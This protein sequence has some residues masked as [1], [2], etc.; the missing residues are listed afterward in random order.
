MRGY[1]SWA[2]LARVL[3][4]ERA[5][6][7]REVS[8]QL[9]PD[10]AD[11][12]GSLRW[13]L[14]SLRRAVDCQ[15]AFTG[16]PIRLGLPAD[17]VTDV[18]LLQSGSLALETGEEFLE[19]IE[20][21][22]G[23]E[24]ATWLLV[25][26]QRIGGLIDAQLRERAL[27]AMWGGDLDIAVQLAERAVRRLPFDEPAHILLVKSLASS[28]QSQ[29]AR[30]HVERT[31]EMFR[32][33]L[34]VSPSPALSS[35][36]RENVA[37]PPQGVSAVAIA[38]SLLDAGSAALAAGAVDAGLDC[39]RRATAEADRSRDD[40][41]R[42]ACLLELGTALVH[43]VRGYDD[44]GAVLLG[45]AAE[46]AERIG[47]QNAAVA[48]RRELGYVDALAGRRPQAAAHLDR[49]LAMAD[50]DAE[51]MAGVHSVIGFNLVDW[52]RADDGIAQ[53]EVA[54][55]LARSIGNTR[56][57]AWALGIGS[58][59]QLQ[60]GHYD[61]AG[62]W[63]DSCLDFVD[64]LRWVAFRPWPLVLRAELDLL[65]GEDPARVRSGLEETFALSCQL[66]DPCWEGATARVIAL[67]HHG[68]GDAEAALAWITQA[69][70]RC[71]RET[72]GYVAMHAAIL[73]DDARIS[74]AAG[75]VTRADGT[76][77]GLVALA[78]RCHM[79]ASLQEAL[80]LLEVLA[81]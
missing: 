49:A 68:D 41:L 58:W 65:Q 46:T 13:C 38:R 29:A 4:A 1:Q 36:A 22:C 37:D 28:G 30:D 21:R 70:E 19:G 64:D 17:T 57:E 47:D 16:D 7:R 18:A 43:S 10:T 8:A 66:A 71:L 76:A 32:A 42:G 11:P 14:A 20:P 50:G 55:D 15:D 54:I 56:R 79:D 9:F 61:E 63:L 44:E 5:L 62:R 60:S 72:D 26:R 48:A 12:L 80:G 53:F 67:T 3:L 40:A 33:E 34:G 2:L 81:G 78:A 59:G 74:L 27:R 35:A 69:R 24:F 23:P 73:A 75:H 31:A 77:R 45:Q 51:L 6:T 39:L 25:Q 52:G